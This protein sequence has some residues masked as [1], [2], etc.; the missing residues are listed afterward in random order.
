[1]AIEA[2]AKNGIFEVDEITMEYLKDRA[3]REPRVFKADD[4]AEYDETFVID[5]SEIRPTVAFPH[6]PEK[7]EDHR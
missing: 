5:L 4:D 6:L 2:G 7:Y 1:M 3:K